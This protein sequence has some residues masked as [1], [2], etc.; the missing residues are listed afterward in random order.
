MRPSALGSR[1]S[2]WPRPRHGAFLGQSNRTGRT[3]AY[4]K[5]GIGSKEALGRSKCSSTFRFYSNRAWARPQARRQKFFKK[6]G[7]LSQRYFGAQTPQI[8]GP[9]GPKSRLNRP[10]SE[11]KPRPASQKLGQDGKA[12]GPKKNPILMSGHNKLFLMC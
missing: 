2:H 10:V 3:R 7:F 5:R 11:W 6:T 4:V 1:S 8:S 9:S 12:L